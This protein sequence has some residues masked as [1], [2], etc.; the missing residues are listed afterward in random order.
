MVTCALVGFGVGVVTGLLAPYLWKKL[1]DKINQVQVFSGDKS[2]KIFPVKYRQIE[3]KERVKRMLTSGQNR[4]SFR[5]TV[6]FWQVVRGWRDDHGNDHV[7]TVEVR[8]SLR[9]AQKLFNTISLPE[10]P[11]KD[12]KRTVYNFVR[13]YEVSAKTRYSILPDFDVK[14]VWSRKY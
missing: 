5:P 7:T 9:K 3:R 14:L 8:T 4:E 10:N 13:L 2:K 6:K 1:T 11:W 12:R